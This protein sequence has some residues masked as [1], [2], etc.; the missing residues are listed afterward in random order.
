MPLRLLLCLLLIAPP[1]HGWS[2]IGHRAV[3]ELAEARLTPTARQAVRELL[4]AEPIPSLAA[5]STWPDE[6]RGTED[7]RHTAP[8]HYVNFPR[9]GGC[10]YAPARDCPDGDCV[11]GAINAQL[12]ILADHTGPRVARAQALKFL[13]HF[14]ADV[15]QPLHA[16]YGHD[17]GGNSYQLQFQEQGTNLH[18]VWDYW[19]L[20]TREPDWLDYAKTLAR[21]PQP[22]A[23]EL[24]VASPAEWAMESC[25]IVRSRGLYP[26]RGRLDPGYL[27]RWR[28]TAE[29]RL[30]QAAARLAQMLNQALGE[31]GQDR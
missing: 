7:Y 14:V 28:P 29:A 6:V 8:W 2:K 31:P 11:V 27:D 23:D 5:V 20:H 24:A 1:V 12:R 26:G 9:R 18:G 3:G 10:R 22:G 30:R 13:V 4:A 21:Q 17:R 15:H 19:I 16:G 25:R